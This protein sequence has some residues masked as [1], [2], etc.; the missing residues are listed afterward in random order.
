MSDNQQNQ[1]VQPSVALDPEELIAID[2]ADSVAERLAEDAFND[3]QAER[4]AETPPA[5]CGE[6][7]DF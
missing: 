5:A 2:E 3:N 7:D 1:N 6:S 4:L